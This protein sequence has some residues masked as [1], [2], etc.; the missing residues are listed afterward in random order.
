MTDDNP[1]VF[2]K[3]R[4]LPGGSNLAGPS[5]AEPKMTLPLR[6]TCDRATKP[7][8]ALSLAMVGPGHGRHQ[9]PLDAPNPGLSRRRAFAG[10]PAAGVAVMAL[11]KASHVI[12]GACPSTSAKEHGKACP[13]IND[14]P[15]FK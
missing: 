11:I 6:N 15:H 1:P 10:C 2:E 12:L 14:F 7:S 3:H 4:L 5:Q 9:P 13:S 8:L